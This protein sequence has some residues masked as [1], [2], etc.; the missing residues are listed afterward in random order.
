MR[1][2]MTVWVVLTLA[3]PAFATD[4]TITSGYYG[5][6]IYQ[7]H[8]TLLMTGGG[9]NSIT[10]EDYS[11]LDIRNTT[12]FVPGSGGI[13]T[14][15]LTDWSQLD[16]SVGQMYWLSVVNSASAVL[17]GG[18]IENLQTAQ[19]AWVYGAAPPIGGWHPHIEMIVKEWNYNTASK[20]LSGLWEDNSL[21]NIQLVNVSGYSPTID[22]IKFTIIP[23]PATLLLLG[24]GG[25]LLR[26]K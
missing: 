10:A 13:G 22:N 5:T 11:I 16:F 18:R 9:V 26:R 21:F 24:L 3:V 2:L 15:D 6:K 8:D 14:L 25:L 4:Y 12:A 7:N 20:R 17:S 23:E 19:I 1:P